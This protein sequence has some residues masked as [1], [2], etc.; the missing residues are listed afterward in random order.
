MA[1]LGPVLVDRRASFIEVPGLSTTSFPRSAFG[2]IGGSL[3][4]GNPNGAVVVAGVSGL[5][6]PAID[7]GTD[8]GAVVIGGVGFSIV[9]P[10]VVTDADDE[11]GGILAFAEPCAD[12]AGAEGGGPG[13]PVTEPNAGTAC[14]GDCVVARGGPKRSI[15]T[16]PRFE[17][18]SVFLRAALSALGSL[19][20][21]PSSWRES[22]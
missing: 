12:T 2:P 4:V 10:R 19:L 22:S 14:G 20:I 8:T 9:K 11:I 6:L 16:V 13:R 15:G 21:S 18:T 1:A 5:V 3:P 7:T 17:L